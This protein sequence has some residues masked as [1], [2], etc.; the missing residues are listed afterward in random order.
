[1]E[2]LTGAL[3]IVKVVIGVQIV[4]QE[5]Q[6]KILKLAAHQVEGFDPEDI[7]S[8]D[9]AGRQMGQAGLTNEQ[10]GPVRE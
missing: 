1:M 10:E 2:A 9:Q 4:I 6:G 5:G 3:E 7:M 8:R